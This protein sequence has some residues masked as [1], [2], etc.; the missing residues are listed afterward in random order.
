[1]S[2]YAGV[3]LEAVIVEMLAWKATRMRLISF[4]N[5]GQLVFLNAD[6]GKEP[7]HLPSRPVIRIRIRRTG[8]RIEIKSAMALKEILPMGLRKRGLD[9]GR[10]YMTPFNVLRVCLA[11][12]NLLDR[13]LF[14]L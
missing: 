8:S 5:D 14:H 11:I 2:L 7:G 13:G 4:Y 1:M 9:I 12:T 10:V 3:I 6:T